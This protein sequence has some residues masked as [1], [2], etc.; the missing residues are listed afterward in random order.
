MKDLVSIITPTYNSE[1]YISETIESIQAQTHTN[2]EL[3]I[4]DD[5]STDV[6]VDIIRSFQ[7]ND[8]RIKL[9]QLDS[10]QGAGVARNHS[11]KQSS[12]QFIAF[13]DSDDQWKPKKLE[14]QIAFMQE[15][16]LSFTFSSYE[17]INSYGEYISTKIITKE[18]ITYSD[19]LKYNY[20]GCLTAIIDSSLLG[21]KS[22][23]TIRK[24]QDYALWLNILKEIK[25]TSAM[26]ESLAIYRNRPNSISSNKLKLIKYN[27]LVFHLNQGFS[28]TQST[29]LLLR[30]IY[31]YLQSKI[32][33]LYHN[34]FSQKKEH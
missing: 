26:L 34:L 17:I 22:F 23:P 13:C 8:P 25:K 32:G 14:K 27:W 28:K 29:L 20:V 33:H 10:N 31:H 19:M 30:F 21:K 7:K 16:E 5:C 3:L 18:I 11:I 24:R 2:W 9:F 1:K 15:K 12:G 6:T 4:T